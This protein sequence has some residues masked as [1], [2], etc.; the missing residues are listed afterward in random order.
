MSQQAECRKSVLELQRSAAA[1]EAA[2]RAERNRSIV[3]K[4]MRSIYFLAKNKIPHTTVYPNLIALQIAN[5]DWLLEQHLTYGAS[6]AQYTSK[7]SAV[8]LLK[9]LDTWLERKQ[10]QSLRSSPYFSIVADVSRYIHTERAIYLL[11]VDCGWVSRG[12]L[13]RYISCWGCRCCLNHTS[14]HVFHGITI[15]AGSFVGSA[16][17]GSLTDIH[18][19]VTLLHINALL[20]NIH[21][22]FTGE[23]VD[24]LSSTVFNPASFPS[25]EAALSDY[26]KKE[27]WPNFMAMKQQLSVMV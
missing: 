19:K 18:D 22:R 7:F 11:Q 24:I 3:L 26:G 8:M 10:V 1:K 23:A 16:S 17:V 13:S 20:H 21:S 25:E 27:V 12:A 2:C 5:G 4:L 6:N 9:T 14:S 15:T